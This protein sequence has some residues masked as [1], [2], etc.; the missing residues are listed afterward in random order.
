MDVKK[1]IPQLSLDE[2]ASLCSGADW[3]HT[4]PIERLL[5]PSVMVSDGRHGLRKQDETNS[6][7][8]AEGVKV[9]FFPAA[10]ATACSFDK[11]LLYRMAK[12][13]DDDIQLQ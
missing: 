11:D 6:S 2:K 10:C 1:L 5:I 4:K 3:W 9:I 12:A 8:F 7:L 13:L